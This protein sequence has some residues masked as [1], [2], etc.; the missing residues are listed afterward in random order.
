VVDAGGKLAGGHPLN[1]GQS[2]V[3]ELSQRLVSGRWAAEVLEFP[4][5][6]LYNVLC[7]DPH[8]ETLR[9]LRFGSP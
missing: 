9:L 7:Y 5:T 2:G 6:Q 1:L 8:D 3:C 4:I